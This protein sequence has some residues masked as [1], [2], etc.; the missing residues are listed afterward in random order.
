[1]A[2]FKPSSPTRERQADQPVGA[3]RHGSAMTGMVQEPGPGVARQPPIARPRPLAEPTPMLDPLITWVVATAAKVPRRPGSSTTAL[4]LAANPG[5]VSS[6]DCCAHSLDDPRRKTTIVPAPT[7]RRQ[8][9]MTQSG[10]GSGRRY[11]TPEYE[12]KAHRDDAA[13]SSGRSLCHATGPMKAAEATGVGERPARAD[14]GLIPR[15]EPEDED[16]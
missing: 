3:P 6:R 15:L 5:P 7:R 9:S 13:S 2:P 14:A 8:A 1:V 11:D 16:Q 4:G 10:R 12:G